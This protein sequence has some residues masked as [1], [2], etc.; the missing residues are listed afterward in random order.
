MS[1]PAAKNS[2]P[3]PGY[4]LIERLGRGGYGEVWKCEAPGGMH[5]AIKF[6]FGDMEGFGT[7]GQAAEQ[8][9]KSLNRVKTIRHP[10][11]LSIERFDI[12][13]G[14]LLIVM[15]L[16]DRNMWDRFNECLLE[17]KQGIPHEEL[18]R[19]MEEVAEALD[20]MNGHYQIQHLDIK[21]QNLFLV[22]NHVKV[23]DFGLAKDLDGA[24]ADVTGGVTPT[25]A[26][27]EAFDGW[28]SRHSDQYS[29][30]IVYQEMLT[31]RRPFT[32]SNTRQL[33]LQHLSAAPDL[34]SLQEN[35]RDAVARALS[36]TPTDRFATCAEFVKALRGHRTPLGPNNEAPTEPLSEMITPRSTSKRSLTEISPPPPF[37]STDADGQAQSRRLPSLVTPG[38]RAFVSPVAP[39]TKHRPLA[40]Q[41]TGLPKN[42]AAPPDRRGDGVLF[43]A[44]FV[45]LGGCGMRALAG[46]R[47]M[48]RAKFNHDRLPNT[49]WLAID[50]DPAAVE[51]FL[52]HGAWDTEEVLLTR[53]QRPTHY[54]H[55]DT[56]PNVEAWLPADLLYQIPRSHLTEGNR[57]FGRL[58]LCDHYQIICHRIRGALAAFA[59]PDGVAQADKMTKLG[60][61][62]NAPRVFLVGSLAGGTAS[63]MM[64]DLAYLV[65]REMRQ[66]GFQAGQVLGMMGLPPIRSSA[67][68]FNAKTALRELAHF[69]NAATTYQVLFDSREQP[70]TDAERPF[71]RCHFVPAGESGDGGRL[72]GERLA[73][74]LYAEAFTEAGR[75]AHPDGDA[76]AAPAHC[77][78]SAF[79][80]VWPHHA[81][82]RA[83]SDR[84]NR[85]ILAGWAAGGDGFAHPSLDPLFEKVWAD[86]G[87]EIDE[88][89][90]AFAAVMHDGDGRTPHEAVTAMLEPFRH[91]DK[92]S[93]ADSDLVRGLI[94]QILDLVGR[95]GREEADHP[96]RVAGQLIRR[97]KDLVS[98]AD[99]KLITAVVSVI[100]QPGLRLPAADQLIHRLEERLTER[101][102]AVD[103][104]IVVAEEQVH[105]EYARLFAL[106]GVTVAAGASRV[107]K[108]SAAGEDAFEDVLQWVDRRVDLLVL[109]RILA[110]YRT[111][112]TNLPEYIREVHL[113]RSQLKRYAAQ[114][115]DGSADGSDKSEIVR[116]YFGSAASSATEVADHVIR[117]L[118]P[119]DRQELEQTLQAKIRHE[120]RGLVNM[121]VKPKEYGDALHRLLADQTGRLVEPLVSAYAAEFAAWGA[122]AESL[123]DQASDA[124][125]K[126]FKAVPGGA[127]PSLTVVGLPDDSLLDD[128]K[129]VA[130]NTAFASAKTHGELW[131]FRECRLNDVSVLLQSA[132]GS[133]VTPEPSATF[134]HSRQDVPW[135]KS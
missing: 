111:L 130:G 7:D 55:R 61:R 118:P 71:R 89:K 9:Y 127:Q 93:P 57:A 121:C 115:P 28:V 39:V 46:V 125:A 112:R 105:D 13:D 17:G 86:R 132:S 16:A 133:A 100:E 43:P 107:G 96:G 94:N 54:L 23:A 24:R 3:I 53:L 29:L 113:C 104:K 75:L 69:E 35:D 34:S 70:V 124:S 18:L 37:R 41:T 102:E 97:E 106:M 131:V 84:L 74:L 123:L 129:E 42:T 110:V 79:R 31:G 22:H 117:L 8:E 98:E 45:G 108:R 119:A 25:Y 135:P 63:G 66:M 88:L 52:Q 83:C 122:G 19:Y 49:H 40:P 47:D 5:K 56:L 27:P 44:L 59:D 126:T 65:R 80:A 82:V 87:L 10:F 81:V 36:K 85:A 99:A 92:K 30:A 68:Y 78:A 11:I 114:I 60:F 50:T 14:Q 72:V 38:H 32:G 77:V 120:G 62:G 103:R 20:L 1:A 95:V 48:L 4:R 101:L 2:E 26:P 21:P 90:A 51:T 109:R 73:A 12:I 6:V 134:R 91:L 33:I 116:H 15:E 58:A 64:L 76:P 67:G 128:A